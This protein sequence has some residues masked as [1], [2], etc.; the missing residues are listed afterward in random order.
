IKRIIRHIK[1]AI[2]LKGG[3]EYREGAIEVLRY[4]KVPKAGEDE[5]EDIWIWKAVNQSGQFSWRQRLLKRT[6]VRLHL[7]E[8]T[9]SYTCIPV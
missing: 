5:W 4:L 8:S 6:S 7:M 1:K 3:N 2:K 9:L